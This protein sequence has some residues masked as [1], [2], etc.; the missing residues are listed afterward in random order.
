MGYRERNVNFVDG[1]RMGWM[2]SPL[3]PIRKSEEASLY[4][5]DLVHRL[6]NA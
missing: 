2:Y 1:W 6:K 5:N 3:Q 4:K